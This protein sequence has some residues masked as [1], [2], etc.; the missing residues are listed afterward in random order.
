[1]SSHAH[2]SLETCFT[3]TSKLETATNLYRG[4]FLDGMNFDEESGFYDW[5]QFHRRYYFRQQL[6]ALQHLANHSQHLNQYDVAYQY[7]L[8]QIKMEPVRESAHRQIMH[9][10][11]LTGQRSAA[12]EQY[13]ICCHNLADELGIEPEPETVALLEQIKAGKVIKTRE[14]LHTAEQRR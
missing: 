6:E 1:M 4:D 8:R 13:S 3:C 7:A 11:A 14:N 9:P 12:I 5:V 10:F 2:E